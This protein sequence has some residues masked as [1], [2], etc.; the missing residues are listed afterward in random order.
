MVRKRITIGTAVGNET[1]SRF[2]INTW[3]MIPH[4]L[5]SFGLNIAIKMG[6]LIHVN[7]TEIVESAL[8]NNTDYLLFLDSDTLIWEGQLEQL[9]R[10]AEENNLD[11]VS[12][13]CN[14][15]DSPYRRSIY[16]KVEGGYKFFN[17]DISSSDIVEVDGVGLAV[18]LIKTD[19]FKKLE[20]PWFDISWKRD[21]ENKL[22]PQGEDL[23][24][25]SIAKNAGFKIFV[26]K[27]VKT[28]HVGGVI[29]DEMYEKIG[30]LVL[31]LG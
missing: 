20:Q 10:D 4:W 21:K 29:T 25:C 11:I 5:K 30:K 26:D 3:G 9:V 19:V 24:F 14:F 8:A 6:T 18:C 27:R 13:V 22:Y 17:V 31:K 12:G 1:N 15:K 28:G 23:Y 7:R 16:R 2:I